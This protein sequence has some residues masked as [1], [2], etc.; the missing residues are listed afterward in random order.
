MIA[1]TPEFARAPQ[2]LFADMP[3][4]LAVL[5]GCL[6]AIPC[7]AGN[8][9][10]PSP[11]I[12]VVVVDDLG[13]TDLGCYSSSFYDTPRVDALARAGIRFTQAYSASPVCSPTRAALMTGRH[14]VRVGITDWIRGFQANDPLLATPEDRDELALEEVT[15]AEVLKEHGYTTGYVG[16]WHLG[17]TEPYWPEHQG[18]DVNIGGFSMGSPPGGYY[19]P[20]K[21]PRLKDG[22]DGEYLTNRLTDEAIGFVRE[23]AEAPFFLYLAF[24]TVHTPIQGCDK[25]DDHYTAKRAGLS[26]GE[27]DKMRK[28]GPAKTRLHQANPKYAAMV[29]SMDENVGRLLDELDRLEL[30][31][32]TVVV[33]TSDNGG[34]ST[35]PKWTPPT[36][37]LP[38]RAGKG[39]CYEGGIRVPLIIRAPGAAKPGSE[40]AQTAISMDLFPTLL[41]LAGLPSRPDLH[42]DGLSLVPAIRQPDQQQPR[43]L[44]WHFPHYHASGWTHGTAIRMGDLKLIERYESG[45]RELYNL[46]DDLSEENDLS[47]SNPEAVFRLGSALEAWHKKMG[48]AMP[49]R[50][51]EPLQ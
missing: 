45:T 28:E 43:T 10:D 42:R 40:S 9:P 33:F 4:A 41:D 19:A 14:P 23:H 22:P 6:L 13:W 27:P 20:Y 12:I 3:V 47:E 18:F 36:S 25:W 38:L 2:R 35:E 16:K 44:V 11:N 17:E 39:W 37:V 5:A 24:Y 7:K 46:A 50:A 1:F 49:E 30:A 29:R 32:D 15:I 48:S 31:D 34:L 21:N 51:P 8:R 26:T